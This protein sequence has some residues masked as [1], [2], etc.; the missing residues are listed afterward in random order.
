MNIYKTY[1]K[2]KAEALPCN[3]VRL[4]FSVQSQKRSLMM[5]QNILWQ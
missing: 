1:G 3:G 4:W 2:G 5:N